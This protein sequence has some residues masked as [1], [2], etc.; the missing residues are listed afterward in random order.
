M[1]TG[2]VVTLRVWPY[3]QM[4]RV[5]G[6]RGAISAWRGRR[7]CADGTVF[8]GRA[9][10][11]ACCCLILSGCR[12]QICH[13]RLTA[14]GREDGDAGDGGGVGEFVQA[15][16]AGGERWRLIWA[17]SGRVAGR[18]HALSRRRRTDHGES[19]RRRARGG[20]GAGDA[21]ADTSS[22][23]RSFLRAE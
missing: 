17:V 2:Y 10:V 6:R 20:V 12:S 19:G 5:S 11:A 14:A 8:G 23:V 13:T 7:R 22:T 18:V 3:V 16:G 15:A 9:P 21:R 4:S 1:R